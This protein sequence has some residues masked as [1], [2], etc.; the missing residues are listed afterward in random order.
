MN[1][2]IMMG[3][4]LTAL[5]LALSGCSFGLPQ[6]QSD[7]TRTFVLSAPVGVTPAAPNPAPAVSAPVIRLRHVEVASYLRG[8]SL[9]IRRGE[10]EVEFRE[11]ARW[12]EPLE[13]GVTRVL[14]EE[15]L[16][17]GAASAVYVSGIP[18]GDTEA[19]YELTVRVMACEGGADGS[20][21]FRAMWELLGTG[22]RQDVA[23]RG[24]YRPTDLRWTP[25][26]E[27]TLAAALSR[28]VAG[29]ADEIGNA[30]KK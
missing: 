11:F 16:A 5:G 10:N 7:P 22:A 9:V 8:H 21:V 30:A 27:A 20:V 6:A 4:T 28:A 12:A 23:G 24:D 25:R 2:R 18:M 29:L 14:R 13:Q 15:L 3:G 26:N 19:R 17:S 1:T